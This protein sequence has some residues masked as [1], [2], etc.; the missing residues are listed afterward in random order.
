VACRGVGGRLA[1]DHHGGVLGL[2]DPVAGLVARIL[3]GGEAG[4]RHQRRPDVLLLGPAQ[5]RR[6]HEAVRR[7]DKRCALTARGREQA[8][9]V[10]S[11]TDA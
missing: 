1:V 3:V 8:L 6:A 11:E 4:D 9:L 2:L 7:G 5:R 10:D